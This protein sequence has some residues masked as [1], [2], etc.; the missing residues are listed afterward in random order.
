MMTEL[1]IIAK[2]PVFPHYAIHH[3]LQ[4][5]ITYYSTIP[6]KKIVSALWNE[7]REIPSFSL[8]KSH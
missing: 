1:L 7:A 6:M 8:K 4:Y 5:F 3:N 2:L